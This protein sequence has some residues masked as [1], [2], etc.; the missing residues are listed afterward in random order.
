MKN[1]SGFSRRQSCVEACRT[2]HGTVLGSKGQRRRNFFYPPPRRMGHFFR[3]SRR[4]PGK[5]DHPSRR[6]MKNFSG[7]SRRQSCVEACR[8]SHGTVLGSK[9]QRRRNFFYP[10][11]R[12]MG[13]FFRPSRRPPG[14]MDGFGVKSEI[15]FIPRPQPP[16]AWEDPSRRRMKIFPVFL[17]ANRVLKHVAQA[18][19]RF[20]GQRVKGGEIFFILL[21]GGWGTFSA[22]AAARLGKWTILLGGG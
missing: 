16:P 3:P 18:T 22:P 4:P 8:T 1:F 11:P 20:W 21:R 10:P 9:G 12:R 7:F 5:M 6:R 17:D 2:S 15:F 14:K 19:A 13:H